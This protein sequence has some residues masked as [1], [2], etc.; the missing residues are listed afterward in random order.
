VVV[1]LYMPPEPKRPLVP[2][3]PATGDLTKIKR[4]VPDRLD[5]Q[6]PYELEPGFVLLQSQDPPQREGALPVVVPPPDLG[7]GPHLA[8]AVQWFLFIPVAL[9]VYVLLLRREARKHG[10]LLSSAHA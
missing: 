3:D 7:E 1:G 4:I 8:Y 5:E 10:P 6:M 9:T 2:D